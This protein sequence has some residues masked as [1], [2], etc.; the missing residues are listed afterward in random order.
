MSVLIRKRIALAMALLLAFVMLAACGGNNDGGSNGQEPANAA[1]ANNGGGSN[2]GN[3]ESVG[4]DAASQEPITLTFFDKNVGDKFTDPVAQEITKRTGITLEIQ[5]PTGN[6]DEKL[7][8]MLAS[9]D[10]P[11]A[12][13]MAR[14]DLL[15]KYTA[16]GAIIP[17]NDLIDKYGSNIKEMYGD[18]LNKTRYKDGKNYYLSSWYGL[19]P[20]PVFA[21]QMRKD[22]LA[23]LAPDKAEG[24]SPFTAEEFRSVLKAFQEKYPTIDGKKTIPMTMDGENMGSVL[25]T[26]KGMFGI[27]SYHETDEGLQVDYRHPNYLPMLKYANSLYREGLIDKEWA[28]NKKQLVEQKLSNG[29]VF[30]TVGAFWEWGT[31][32]AELSKDGDRSKQFYSYKVLGDGVG[33]DQTTYGPRSVLGWDG[34]VITKD[35][36]HPER[37]MQLF[38]FLASEEGQYLLLWGVEGKDWD[39]KDGKHVPRPETLQGFLDNWNEFSKTTGIRKWTYFVKNGNGSDGTPYDLAGKYERSDTFT[40]AEKNLA[41]STWDTSPY[42]NLSPAGGTPDAL[43]HQKI[44]DIAAQTLPKIINAPSEAEVEKLFNGMLADMEKNGL[45]E[46]EK[47]YTKNYQEKMEL[48]K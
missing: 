40:A 48:W 1:G 47:I 16:A 14:G 43:K 11:D 5:Q 17:L 13:M 37:T 23:E 33:P 30:A 31:P 20:D 26:F 21:F 12:I 36:K 9:G 22:L 29:A 25:G 6:P 10:L 35:N 8:L 7:N 34:I 41:G 39:M 32:N 42:D 2:A 28:V 45:K 19:D 3:A 27:K 38:D 46:L 24:Q 18:V 44:S 15:D 4:G